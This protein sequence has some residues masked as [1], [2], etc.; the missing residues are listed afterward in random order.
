MRDEFNGQRG[1]RPS[2][3][4]KGIKVI[5][6]FWPSAA[7]AA[8]NTQNDNF[9]IISVDLPFSMNSLWCW[10][11][12]RWTMRNIIYIKISYL[13]ITSA[14]MNEWKECTHAMGLECCQNLI[15]WE[16]LVCHIVSNIGMPSANNFN[17]VAV[18]ISPKSI[19]CRLDSV[20]SASCDFQEWMHNAHMHTVNCAVLV[21]FLQVKP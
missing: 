21:L 12:N 17:I 3:R 11:F 14:F 16:M 9:F 1:T 15:R 10:L 13:M 19:W 7:F 8:S 5:S 4:F 2:M 6:L 18:W 20:W